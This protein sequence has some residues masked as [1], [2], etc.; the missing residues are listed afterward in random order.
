MRGVN[1]TKIQ[2]IHSWD[3][4]KKP[5]LNNEYEIKN[6]GQN[7]KTVAVKGWV[8]VSFQKLQ[9]YSFSAI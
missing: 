3:T 2:D 8:L 1:L 9:K 5:H 4:I 6:E 7:C